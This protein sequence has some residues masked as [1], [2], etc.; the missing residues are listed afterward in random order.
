MTKVSSGEQEVGEWRWLDCSFVHSGNKYFIEH[1][2]C[3]GHFSKIQE[4][5]DTAPAIMS[6]LSGGETD[7]NQQSF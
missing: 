7:F 2:L 6:Q 4:W 3:A 1:L 5:A